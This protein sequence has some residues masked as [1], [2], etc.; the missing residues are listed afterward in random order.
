MI[1]SNAAYGGAGQ[2]AH[3][4]P[5]GSGGIGQGGGIYAAGG[6]LSL[7]GTASSP[8]RIEGNYADGGTGGSGVS[9]G[10]G[11]NGQGGGIYV[12]GKG[13]LALTLKMSNTIV[14]TNF[15]QGG[16][17]GS[18]LVGPFGN[19]GST[20]VQDSMSVEARS[21]SKSRRTTTRSS[22]I[23]RPAPAGRMAVTRKA[24]GSMRRAARFRSRKTP[25]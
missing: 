10:N 12:A 9:G 16:T 15:V 8:N 7:L 6:S 25:S 19:G 3:V 5:G 23:G 24:P 1:A 17:G 11:G 13:S 4:E 2:S 21:R 14:S 18:G 20:R 22:P